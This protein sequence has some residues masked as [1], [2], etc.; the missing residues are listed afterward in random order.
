[1]RRIASIHSTH[2]LRGREKRR[3]AA[4]VEFALTIP[5]FLTLIM[6]VTEIGTA[7]DSTNILSAGLR[8]GGRLATMDWTTVV[9]SGT[10][11]N[12]KVIGDIQNFYTA[13]GLP[14]NEVVVTI[15]SAEGSDMGQDFNLATPSNQG[16]L[17]KIAARLPYS[18]A[19]SI[20]A[21]F[22][23]NKDLSSSLVFRAGRT[24]LVQ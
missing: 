1:M 16:R 22:M 8:E 10:T 19:S 11:I 2:R 15:T 5:I 14:G 12:Q 18:S 4:L 13:A 23:K 17:F 6:G 20:P 21:S 24:T 7:L 3:G 9:P